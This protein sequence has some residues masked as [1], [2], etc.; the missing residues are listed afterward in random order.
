MNQGRRT[1]NFPEYI[2][3]FFFFKCNSTC[4]GWGQ[5]IS[6]SK[7]FLVWAE[8]RLWKRFW[9]QRNSITSVNKPLKSH[10]DTD[11]RRA[12]GNRLGHHI[13]FIANTIQLLAGK[14]S[15]I[16]ELG[17]PQPLSS[18]YIAFLRSHLSLPSSSLSPLTVRIHSVS[19][20]IS[21]TWLSTFFTAT[22][23]LSRIPKKKKKHIAAET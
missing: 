23:N 14:R 3:R 5:F 12:G 13:Q 2:K 19:S 21:H 9:G 22:F 10:T 6:K 16:S 1:L 4:V 18:I 15:P 11:E 7:V 8:L 20:S 17:F